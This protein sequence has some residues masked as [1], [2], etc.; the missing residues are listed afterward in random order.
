MLPVAIRESLLHSSVVIVDGP[1]SMFWIEEVM[2]CKRQCFVPIS[3]NP[4]WVTLEISFEACALLSAETLSKTNNCY[5]STVCCA[6]V[7][8]FTNFY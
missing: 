5:E 6:A 1:G 4:S 8:L 7:L 2:P 3:T